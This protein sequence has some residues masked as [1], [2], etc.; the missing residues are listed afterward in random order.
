MNAAFGKDTLKW[1]RGYGIVSFSKK[2][3]PGVAH[4]VRNQREHHSNGTTNATLE[5]HGSG[6]EG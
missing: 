5:Q 6:A 1:H 4:Y 2:H 3:L